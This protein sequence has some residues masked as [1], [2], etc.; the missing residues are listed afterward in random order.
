MRNIYSSIDI[1]S[2]SIKIVTGEY[3]NGNFNVLASTSVP[4]NGVRRGLITDSALA[5]E[6][7][8]NGVL[9]HEKVLGMMIKKAIVT[10]PSNDRRINVVESKIPILGEFV[11]GFDVSKVLEE[12]VAGK[13]KEDEEVVSVVPIIFAIDDVQHMVNPNGV[14]A[15]NLSVKAVLVAAPK[16]QIMDVIN[17]VSAAGVEVIEITFGCIGDY[18]ELRDN[19]TDGQVGAIINIGRD[20]TEVSVFNKGIL[21]KSSIINLGSKNVDKDISYVY[22]TDINT[23]RDLKENFAFASRKDS[24]TSESVDVQISDGNLSTINQTDVSGV[25][26]ARLEELL[27]LA[28]KETNNLTKR[29][30]SYIIVTGGITELP[31]VNTVVENALGIEGRVHKATTPGIRDNKYTSATGIIR[32]F[33]DK[34]VLREREVSFVDDDDVELMMKNKKSMIELTD[35]TIISKIY[36]YLSNN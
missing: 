15:D 12:A 17:V 9:E 20:K 28:K 30:I 2:D 36:G 35:N 24:D 27:N 22:D 10:V 4:S 23:S 33:H 19:Q 8:K 18:Y 13:V 6:S 14:K 21:I 3:V 1:G 26:E 7:L 29:K 34:M 5:T 32:Y 16:K 11:T 25:V 31:G